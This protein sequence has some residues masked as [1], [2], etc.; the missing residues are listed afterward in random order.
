MFEELL[1]R[2]P[3]YELECEPEWVVSLWARS[4]GDVP[5]RCG[6]A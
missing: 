5:V 2:M 1:E 6:G 3:E 4:Y